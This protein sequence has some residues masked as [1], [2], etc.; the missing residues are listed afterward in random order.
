MAARVR[1]AAGAD[2]RGITTE[3]VDVSAGGLRVRGAPPPPYL[4]GQAVE[5]QIWP[6]ETNELI[7]P[8]DVSL[9]GEGIVVRVEENGGEKVHTAL[10][11]EG[12]LKLREPFESLFLY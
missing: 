3:L 11:F 9:R 7:A 8:G 4:E 5:V 1:L 10:R 12:P 2:G 6:A